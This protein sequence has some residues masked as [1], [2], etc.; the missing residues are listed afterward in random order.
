MSCQGRSKRVAVLGCHVQFNI[1]GEQIVELADVLRRLAHADGIRSSGEPAAPCRH[2]ASISWDCRGLLDQG[3]AWVKL[4][5]AYIN[6]KIGPASYPEAAAIARDFVKA[7]P[8]RLWDG[9][10]N[11]R[12]RPIAI[13]RRATAGSDQFFSFS[14]RVKARVGW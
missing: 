13:F 3:R 2:R 8:E 1:S 7:P 12:A 11:L 9:G 14:R 10:N 5:G 6:S 4:S